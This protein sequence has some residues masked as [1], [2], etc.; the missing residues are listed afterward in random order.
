MVDQTKPLVTSEVTT[1]RNR[2]REAQRIVSR[3]PAISHR[4]KLARRLEEL[5]AVL[6]SHGEYSEAQE[7][8][9]K[10]LTLYEALRTHGKAVQPRLQGARA[11]LI[12]LSRS[13]EYSLGIVAGV[14]LI[15]GNKVTFVRGS[16]KPP[17]ANVPE[18]VTAVNE[19]HQS[20]IRGRIDEARTK[21]RQVV[22]LVASKFREKNSDAQAEQLTHV[23]ALHGSFARVL[24]L[25]GKAQESFE[26]YRLEIEALARAV[27]VAPTLLR[28]HQRL[29]VAWHDLG[30]KQASAASLAE[31]LGNMEV[32]NISR[33]KAVEAY[34]AALST[35][36]KMALDRPNLLP[37]NLLQEV[38]EPAQ[39]T[40]KLSGQKHLLRKGKR[41]E[42]NSRLEGAAQPPV[43][44]DARAGLEEKIAKETPPTGFKST[45]DDLTLPL[46][47]SR[48]DRIKHFA[49]RTQWVEAVKAD[50]TLKPLTHIAQT[51]PD[52]RQGLLR[53][54]LWK[55]DPSLAQ[56]LKNWLNYRKTDGSKPN[57]IPPDFGL[58]TAA[59]WYEMVDREEGAPTGAQVMEAV[60]RGD[61]NAGELSRRFLAGKRRNDKKASRPSPRRTSKAKLDHNP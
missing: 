32:C 9:Q 4:L 26:A 45:T 56:A 38:P 54:D 40:H 31:Q 61:P 43:S 16:Q 51:Y 49:G 11:A 44:S 58:M 7:A 6:S 28:M 52:R 53:P 17:V 30:D 50:P 25:E 42:S 15:P 33:Q 37:P 47:R 55:I 14:R 12:K 24:E 10:A 57:S 34:D 59:E 21:F 2:V 29:V 39:I 18:I 20:L 36:R 41:D 13:A 35:A 19:V 3:D 8:V 46:L 5:G 1:A 27:L 22:G 48:D 60:G 23:A